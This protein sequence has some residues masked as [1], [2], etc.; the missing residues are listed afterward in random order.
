MSYTTHNILLC[1]I[2]ERSNYNYSLINKLNMYSNTRDEQ[3][4]IGFRIMIF[5]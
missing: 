3:I 2:L 1:T 5:L 4:D